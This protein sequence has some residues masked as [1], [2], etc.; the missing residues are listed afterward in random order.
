MYQPALEKPTIAGIN[1]LIK[2]AETAME[3]SKLLGPKSDTTYCY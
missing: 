1:L 2:N 3:S